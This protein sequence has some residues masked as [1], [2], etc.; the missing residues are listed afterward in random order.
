MAGNV[1]SG[2]SAGSDHSR[3]ETLTPE[4]DRMQT[5]PTVGSGGSPVLAGKKRINGRRQ[6]MSLRDASTAESTI[7]TA[8]DKSEEQAPSPDAL[9]GS[10]HS[11][12]FSI[13]HEL[14]K[15][16]AKS[17]H[18]P[19]RARTSSNG[20][21]S[22][23]SRSRRSGM[24]PSKTGKE[25]SNAK[26]GRTI[27]SN[28]HAKV[29]IQKIK[30]EHKKES[31]WW[32]RLVIFPMSNF[33][34]AWWM[35][36]VIAT[37][38]TFFFETYQIGFP[39]GGLTEPTSPSSV[40]NY[41]LITVFGVDMVIN[42]NLAFFT[43]NDELVYSHRDI[44]NH[45]LSFYF[46]IDLMGVMPFYLIALKISGY[47]Q[48]DTHLTQWLSL[49]RLLRLVR[50]RRVK[51]LFDIIKF[52]SKVSLMSLTLIRNGVAAGVWTHFAACV[53]FFIA[54]QY[55]FDPDN[56]WIGP[57]EDQSPAEVY[58]TTLYWS[59]VT[60]TTVGY[61]DLSPVNTAEQIFSMIYMLL[62]IILMSY[63]IGSITLL[64][65]KNDEATG[66]YR[67]N[68]QT[69][70]NYC[71]ANDMLDDELYP[72][73]KTQL[74]VEFNHRD[75]GDEM[76]LSK[77][78]KTMRQKV[79]YK[80]YSPCLEGTNLMNGIR[81]HFITDFLSACRI[82][83]FSSG[84][85]LL[86]RGAVSSDLF[87]LV[88]GAVELSS[89]ELTRA[90]RVHST[91]AGDEKGKVRRIMEDQD[92]INEISF[93]TESPQIDTVRTL[94]VTKTLIIAKS[95]Y[96]VISNNHPGSV[97]RLLH[98]LLLKVKAIRDIQ[99]QSHETSNIMPKLPK[100]VPVLFAGSEFD[101]SQVSTY[102]ESESGEKMP[103]NLTAA[104]TEAALASVQDLVEMHI[105]RQQDDHTTRFLFAASRD[106]VASIRLMCDQGFDPDSSDYD[107]R[108]ALMVASMKGNIDTIEKL[109]EYGADPHLKDHHGTCALL[110]AIENGHD[111]AIDILLNERTH[112]DMHWLDDARASGLLN[113]AVSDGDIQKL[114]R[115][116]KAN[117][118]LDAGDYDMRRPIHIAASE[119]NMSAFRVLVEA[120]ADLMVLDRWGNS[121]E[122]DAKRARNGKLVDYLNQQNLFRSDSRGNLTPLAEEHAVA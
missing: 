114:Q 60:F 31:N 90:S 100:S 54:K 71:N 38:F 111:V 14:P 88:E 69:L 3:S 72:R 55:D 65:V 13:I 116:I 23:F 10:N 16:E 119:G 33:Y 1:G 22:T 17:S 32:E 35:F 46:W 102:D 98:N 104:Q 91:H 110:E 113:Q 44:A 122:D 21:M 53:F 47:Y 103:Q 20:S 24:A 77:F 107:S 51:Q 67:A 101:A 48:E 99:E 61:G 92:F 27:F 58:I 7:T 115:L 11:G 96:R 63:I 4:T 52:S 64:V 78:P 9:Q 117:V 15:M 59:V 85:E 93:F 34:R 50:M 82:V 25:V 120:G 106:D 12:D 83:I 36:T 70:H 105:N 89:P 121:V 30:E 8:T 112:P 49:L 118:N 18:Q 62:N 37:I 74:K 76:V 81:Q 94:T 97:G 41:L 95:E 57:H 79:L 87:L 68:L 73:L 43:E 45:Y 75:M 66:M 39:P 108:T 28:I 6:L 84:E 80:L 56:T 109:L 29:Q 19:N 2:G 26:A 5:D 42:F 86:T 40:M